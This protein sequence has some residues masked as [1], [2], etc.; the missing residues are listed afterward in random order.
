MKDTLYLWIDNN[1]SGREQEQE[2]LWTL[3]HYLITTNINILQYL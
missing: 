2:L 1:N 3:N